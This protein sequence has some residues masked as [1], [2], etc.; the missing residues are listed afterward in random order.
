MSAT[1]SEQTT[2]IEEKLA[3]A[4]VEIT[5]AMVLSPTAVKVLW[6]VREKHLLYIRSVKQIQ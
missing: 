6:E 4:R 3:E 2:V 1:P 5:N